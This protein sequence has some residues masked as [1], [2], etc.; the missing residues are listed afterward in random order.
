MTTLRVCTPHCG[1][2]PEARLGGEVYEREILRALA[3]RGIVLDILLARHKHLPDELPNWIVH[4]LPIGRGLRWPVAALLLPPLIRRVYDRTRFDVLRAHSLRYIGPAALIARRRYRLDVPV[5]AHHHHLDRGWLN[6]LIEAPV[7]RGVERIVVGSEFARRQASDELGVP[8]EKL[9]VVYYGVDRRFQ[10]A[11]KPERLVERFALEDKPVALFLGGIE[12]R[13]NLF[14]LLDV[15]CQ[16]VRERPAARLIVAGTGPLLPRLRRRATRLGLD[17]RVIFA[18]HVPEA[19]KVEYYN[20]AD[21]LLFP[22]AMEGFG[23]VVAEAMSC[24][25]PVIVSNRG[26]LPELV[27][28]GDGGLVCDPTDRDGFVRATLQLLSDPLLRRKLGDANRA[29]VDR[30]F[31]WDVCAA[32][33]ARIYEDVLAEWR[34][35]PARTGI[36]A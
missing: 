12:S 8:A 17:G 27:V 7:M 18:G 13:K 20:L 1:L 19:E 31:R 34:R 30:L 35:R 28:D 5:V 4:R 10:P 2:D 33:T 6:P 29:R 15:W 22:S 25:L 21:L 16:V 9:S 14:F 24:E 3:G 23:L 32:A 36:P 11:P 26:S